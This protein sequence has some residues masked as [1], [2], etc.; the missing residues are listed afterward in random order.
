MRSIVTYSVKFSVKSY[1]IIRKQIIRALRVCSVAV[2]ITSF[3]LTSVSQGLQIKLGTAM[4]IRTSAEA[5]LKSVG[6]LAAGSVV[7]IP[8]RYKVIK[9]GKIDAKASFNNWLT[10]AGFEK[11]DIQRKVA[12][13]RKD[14]YF[15]V[16]VVS[17][18]KGSSGLNLVGK[19]RFMALRVLAK[20]AGGLVVTKTAHVYSGRA[21]DEPVQPITPA[22]RATRPAAAVTPVVRKPSPSENAETTT[23]PPVQSAPPEQSEPNP[24]STGEEPVADHVE[25]EA[26]TS[27]GCATCNIP[28]ETNNANVDALKSTAQDEILPTVYNNEAHGFQGLTSS[29][30]EA[31]RS[32]IKSDGSYGPWGQMV[33]NELEKQ[34]IFMKNPL[35]GMASSCPNFNSFDDAKKR[36]FW[37]WLMTSMAAQESTCDAG[38]DAPD[39]YIGKG[40]HRYRFNPNGVASGLFQI[41]KNPRLRSNRDDQYGGRYCSGDVYDPQTNIRCG[42]RMLEE[43][44]DNEA[45]PYSIRDNYWSVLRKSGTMTKRLVSQYEDCGA[46]VASSNHRSKKSRHHRRS[47]K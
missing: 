24:E 32:F 33:L 15:P 8:D 38:I 21:N 6:I 41:E 36:H 14:F 30:P 31:C 3:L 44:I 45:G 43:V 11:S 5:G 40:K 9:S 10:K 26:T 18:A 35:P 22:A 2:V 34:P 4:R 46:R 23:P 20:S 16:R 12:N 42:V 39:V 13:P 17:M 28:P 29:F 19:T 27:S 7:E 25:L 37:V 47:R 1:K